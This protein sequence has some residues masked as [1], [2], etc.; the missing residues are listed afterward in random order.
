MNI[1][2]A[3]KKQDKSMIIKSLSRGTKLES[4]KKNGMT[5]LMLA[6]QTSCLETVEHLISIGAEINS[7]KRNGYSALTFACDNNNLKIIEFL[8]K[9]KADTRVKD[10]WNNS[11]RE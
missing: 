6:V 3:V 10:Q 1:F 7:V 9:N 8:I 11:C 4:R 5:P 2:R